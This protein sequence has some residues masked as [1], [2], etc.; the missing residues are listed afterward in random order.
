M[1]LLRLLIIFVFLIEWSYPIFFEVLRDGVSP[2]K[3]AFGL[4][5]VDER[6]LPITFQASFLG[7]A[8]LVVDV[9]SALGKFAGTG[10]VTLPVAAHSVPRWSV[11]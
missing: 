5:V 7:T 4:R 2:G 10:I 3:K 8:L 11:V 6:G 1:L 9:F